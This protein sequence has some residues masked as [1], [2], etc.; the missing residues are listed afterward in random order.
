MRGEI[1]ARDMAKVMG[2]WYWYW[3][4]GLAEEN[5][6]RLQADWKFN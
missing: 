3:C 6:D 5:L 2:W 4:F 1:R